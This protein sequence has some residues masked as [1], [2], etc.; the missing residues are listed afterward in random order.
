MLKRDITYE[1]LDGNKI[2]ETFYF[3]LTKTEIVD[4]EVEHQEGLDAWFRRIVRIEDRKALIGEFKKIILASYGERD[5]LGKR[6]IKNEE[7]RTAFTQSMAY[8]QLFFEMATDDGA[9]TAFLMGILPADVRAEAE[10]LEQLQPPN[11]RPAE[12]IR[13]EK[14]K[15]VDLPPPPPS[16]PQEAVESQN[17]GPKLGEPGF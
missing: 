14:T 12:D 7:M 4:M 13:A 2:T 9:A 8:D 10:R 15:I 16:P 11:I 6:F 1:D 17:T 5:P 3:N